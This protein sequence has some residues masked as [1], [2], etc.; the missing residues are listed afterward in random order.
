MDDVMVAREERGPISVLTMVYAPYNLLGPKL[1]GA[2]A[3]EPE[4]AR[5]AG[6]RAVVLRSG[7]RHFCTGADVSQF[8]AQTG[9]RSSRGLSTLA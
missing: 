7:L 6:S 5:A 9:A 4:A 8:T 2:I 1:I 3:R